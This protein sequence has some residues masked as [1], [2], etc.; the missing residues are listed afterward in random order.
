[1]DICR[2][3]IIFENV[4]DLLTCLEII[5]QDPDI[6]VERVKN[7]LSPDYDATVCSLSL[8]SHRSTVQQETFYGWSGAAG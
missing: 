5:E 6:I 7:R 1:V 8:F 2:Q 4:A 3:C